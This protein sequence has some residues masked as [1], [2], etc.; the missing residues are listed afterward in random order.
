MKDSDTLSIKTNIGV[1]HFKD[2]ISSRAF[3]AIK[4]V[5]IRYVEEIQFK[6]VDDF[7]AKKIKQNV[8]REVEKALISCIA[9]HFKLT[10][11][12]RRWRDE[13]KKKGIFIRSN[14]MNVFIDSIRF[15]KRYMKKFEKRGWLTTEQLEL[16][17]KFCEKSF[18]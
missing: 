7:L 12:E 9:S 3:S 15:D 1:S 6:T 17:Q 2:I 14:L 10:E 4:E 18:A 5:K 16:Y 11:R 8:I 13:V